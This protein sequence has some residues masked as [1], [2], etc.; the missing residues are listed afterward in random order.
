MEKRY[1]PNCGS[2]NITV[3]SVPAASGTD[4]WDCAVCNNCGF[5]DFDEEDEE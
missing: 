2:D 5:P 1:C 3:K 4:F